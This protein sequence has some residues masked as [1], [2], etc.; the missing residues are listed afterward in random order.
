MKLSDLFEDD[1]KPK[2]IKLGIKTIPEDAPSKKF[3]AEFESMTDKLE[4]NPRNRVLGR[5]HAQLRAERYAEVHISDIQSA[6]AGHGTAMMKLICDLADKYDV[7][8]TA[9]V[10]GRESFS[11]DDRS[12]RSD[13]WLLD[14][15]AHWGFCQ[16][17]RDSMDIVRWPNTS[18]G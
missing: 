2:I 8:L 10:Q 11:D 1:D 15:Y 6:A 3:M 4:L 7:K 9:Y 17:D 5:C 13:Q 12:G 16:E 18:Q 14:W